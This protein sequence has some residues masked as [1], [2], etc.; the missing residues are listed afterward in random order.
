MDPD[1]LPLS[2][3]EVDCDGSA[4][5]GT[6]R[7]VHPPQSGTADLRVT[8]RKGKREKYEPA[9]GNRGLVI[10]ESADSVDRPRYMLQF[11]DGQSGE[12]VD[13]WSR[14]ASERAIQRMGGYEAVMDVFGFPE[15]QKRIVCYRPEVVAQRAAVPA[16]ADEGKAT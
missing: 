13:F 16:L 4:C 14:T 12:W 2:M 3:F 1:K 11:R 5:G 15:D 8:V 10:I 7:H 6:G 9:Q